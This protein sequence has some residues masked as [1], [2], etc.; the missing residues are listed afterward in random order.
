[1]RE[2]SSRW[3]TIRL[4]L[5]NAVLITLIAL[6]VFLLRGVVSASFAGAALV[7]GIQVC[8]I[9]IRLLNRY[10]KAFVR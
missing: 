4:S 5:L 10:L 1:M 9:A 6:I 8:D 3:V 7:Y 2:F